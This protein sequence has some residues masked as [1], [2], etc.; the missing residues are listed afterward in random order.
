MWEGRNN[1]VQKLYVDK[2]LNRAHELL[3]KAAVQEIRDIQTKSHLL[4][5]DTHW[6]EKSEDELRAMH[7]LSLQFWFQNIKKMKQWYKT[8]L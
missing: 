4:G 6:L 7:P 2:G 5:R 3:V 1:A 8:T